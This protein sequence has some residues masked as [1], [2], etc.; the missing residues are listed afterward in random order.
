MKRII[1]D[2]A[3]NETDYIQASF[4]M[5][6]AAVVHYDEDDSPNVDAQ[7]EVTRF[8][9]KLTVAVSVADEVVLKHQNREQDPDETWRPVK[10]TMRVYLVDGIKSVLLSSNG[11]LPDPQAIDPDPDYFSYKNEDFRR[12]FFREDNT[13]YFEK[14]TIDGKDYYATWP[15]YSYPAKWN[16][17]AIIDYSSINYLEHDSKLPPEPPYFKLEMDWKRVPDA[18]YDFDQR[19]YYYKIYLPSNKLTRNTWY[20]FYVDVSILG[21]ETDEGKAVL[22]PTCYLLDWQNKSLA[23]NKYAVISKARYLSVDKTHWDINNME[24][25]T[26]PFL[27]SHNVT[28]VPGSV[29]ATRPYYGVITTD[30][31]VGS[32]HKDLHGWIK[33]KE[34]GSYYLDYTNQPSE[35]DNS[36]RWEPSKWLKNTSTSIVLTHPLVNDYNTKKDFD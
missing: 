32:Y 6:G 20:G 5:D 31:P 11:T 18:N 29:T 30:H 1:K 36:E 4:L 3:Q 26:V 7:I 24:T 35:V 16:P 34:D 17:N 2:F 9:S 10:H 27:S 33:Q 25:L 13:S 23:I 15:M 28:V 12:P 8:A 19:K 14:E 22:D 21:S